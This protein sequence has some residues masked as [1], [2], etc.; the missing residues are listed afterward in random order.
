MGKEG[1]WR[2][3]G[4]GMLQQVSICRRGWVQRCAAAG[5]HLKGEESV[6]ENDRTAS[7]GGREKDGVGEEWGREGEQDSN[8][9]KMGDREC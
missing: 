5:Q 2:G 1:G 8:C 3:G 6:L 9:Q 4:E 7:T